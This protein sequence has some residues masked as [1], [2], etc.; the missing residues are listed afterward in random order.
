M[1]LFTTVATLKPVQ[2]TPAQHALIRGGFHAA[3]GLVIAILL[4]IYPRLTALCTLTAATAAFLCLEITRLRLPTLNQYFLSWFTPLLRKQESSKLTGSSYF[5]IGSLATAILFPREIAFLAIL[6]LSFGDPA[7]SIVGA[8][9]GRIK[10]WD[11]TVEGSIACLVVCLL[12]ASMAA[13]IFK[14]PP[15]IVIVVGAFFATIAQLLPLSL[16][17]NITIPLASAT[18]MLLT[19]RVLTLLHT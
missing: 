1:T 8:W 17:D 9:R 10:L 7:A 4:H 12:I 15:P 5:L 11:K 16:N 18:T 13:F 2:F 6:F 14:S 3:G 19:S